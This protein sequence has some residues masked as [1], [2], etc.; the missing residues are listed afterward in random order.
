[1]G[2]EV[3]F[4]KFDKQQAKENLSQTLQKRS[5]DSYQNFLQKDE[6]LQVS[7]ECVLQKVEQNINELSVEELWTLTRWFSEQFT[8]LYPNL[9]S[10]FERELNKEKN[11]NGLY[12]FYEIPSKTPAGHFFTILNRYQSLRNIDFNDDFS[13]DYFHDFLDYAICYTG[14]IS[15]LLIENYYGKEDGF[16]FEQF[17]VIEGKNYQI[18]ENN[19]L[20][21]K[22][23]TNEFDERKEKY[24]AVIDKI[25]KSRDT[26]KKSM[27]ASVYKE[28][29]EQKFLEEEIFGF[30]NQ[31]DSMLA[32]KRGIEDYT[33][34]I[35]ILDSY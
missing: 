5:K 9:D 19:L 13:A 15:Q 1:M 18:M 4:Y 33:G 23:A 6:E 21:F 8:I 29:S 24:M 11:R 26:P 2:R 10:K 17:W 31:F 20:Q 34:H 27:T 28:Y 35:K 30:H 7:F 14:F 3:Y 12:K 32:L 25:V 16:Y 22:Y